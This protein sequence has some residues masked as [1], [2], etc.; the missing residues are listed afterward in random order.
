MTNNTILTEQQI[1]AMPE[2]DYMN[3][4]QLRFLKTY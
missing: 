2:E 4:D 3:S 1:L